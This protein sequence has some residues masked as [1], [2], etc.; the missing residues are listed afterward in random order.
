MFIGNLRRAIVWNRNSFFGVIALIT[1][2]LL[3][4]KQYAVD[5]VNY[6]AHGQS[7]WANEPALAFARGWPTTIDDRRVVVV[8][9][10]GD[11]KSALGR[12]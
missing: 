8:L 10:A 4:I 7:S 3:N 9:T 1:S 2:R 5:I 12:I 11:T 6:R